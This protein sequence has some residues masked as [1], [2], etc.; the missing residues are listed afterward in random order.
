[1][2]GIHI[3][4]CLTAQNN[5]IYVSAEGDGW[6]AYGAVTDITNRT[7][8]RPKGLQGKQAYS[9]KLDLTGTAWCVAD[10]LH[11]YVHGKWVRIWPA[12]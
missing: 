2:P 11:Q 7:V 9:I 5:K 8:I 1:M 3:P 4:F 12:R 6:T 10:G